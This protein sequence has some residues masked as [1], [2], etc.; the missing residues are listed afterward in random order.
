MGWIWNYQGRDTLANLEH[1]DLLLERLGNQSGL[2]ICSRKL[3]K[4][5][6]QKKWQTNE[7]VNTAI[8][9]REVIP[10]KCPDNG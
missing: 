6:T 1:P 10:K 9:T 7:I 3:N 4:T 5:D 8:I 2:Q